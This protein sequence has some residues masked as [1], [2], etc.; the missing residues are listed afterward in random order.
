MQLPFS[1]NRELSDC[2]GSAGRMKERVSMSEAPV[3]KPE[4]F[5]SSG[6]PSVKFCSEGS[7]RLTPVVQA[8]SVMLKV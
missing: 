8:L 7:K 2:A 1:G 4:K 3:Y 5:V 6:E